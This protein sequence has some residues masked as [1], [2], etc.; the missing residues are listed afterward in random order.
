MQPGTTLGHYTILSAIRKG[1]MGEARRESGR[2]IAI[3]TLPK[4]FQKNADRS[5][6]CQ[7][8][9]KLL[10]TLNDSIASEMMIQTSTF[11]QKHW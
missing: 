9:A 10:D 6:R 3:K 2:E 5:G 4:E 8:E 11:R 7:L 1:G